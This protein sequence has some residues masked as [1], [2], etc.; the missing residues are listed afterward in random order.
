LGGKNWGARFRKKNWV[1]KELASILRKV[2][3]E[4]FGGKEG[5]LI[6]WKGLLGY[7]QEG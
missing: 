1:W 7:F 3:E 5:K 2:L 4:N 6:P